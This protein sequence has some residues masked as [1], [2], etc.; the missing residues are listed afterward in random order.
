M[1]YINI[2]YFKYK[3]FVIN[4][5]LIIQSNFKVI[6]NLNEKRTYFST[7][8]LKIIL[9]ISNCFFTFKVIML[10]H[11][12]KCLLMLIRYYQNHV[13]ACVYKRNFFSSNIRKQLFNIIQASNIMMYILINMGVQQLTTV[14]GYF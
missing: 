3:T 2:F 1:L 5:Y 4:K 9:K 13:R 10:R 6:E 7:E 8:Q 12:M 14:L 11:N